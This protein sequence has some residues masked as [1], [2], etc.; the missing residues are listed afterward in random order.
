MQRRGQAGRRASP[1]A[2]GHTRAF[3]SLTRLSGVAVN[4]GGSCGGLR[5][6]EGAMLLFMSG[7]CDG[8]WK[9]LRTG[10]RYCR[11]EGARTPKR[12]VARIAEKEMKR[13]T[14][15][16][17]R[18]EKREEAT[19]VEV[20]GVTTSRGGVVLLCKMVREPREEGRRSFSRAGDGSRR[21]GWAAGGRMQDARR[22]LRPPAVRATVIAAAQ[23]R[24]AGESGRLFGARPPGQPSPHVAYQRCCSLTT[25]VQN[26]WHARREG[27]PG[28]EALGATRGQLGRCSAAAASKHLL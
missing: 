11:I 13:A 3:V 7:R 27:E 17:N 22:R 23:H 6:M 15:T 16:R 19:V 20:A 1:R 8:A 2:E 28:R 14:A 5:Y 24:R 21:K 10:R 12:S 4:R 18:R 9:G 26:P 25:S